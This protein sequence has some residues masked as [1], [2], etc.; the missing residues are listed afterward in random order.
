MWF[1]CTQTH[2]HIQTNFINILIDLQNTTKLA[3]V[4]QMVDARE[5]EK[6]MEKL[7]VFENKLFIAEQ[8][9]EKEIQK[10]LENIRRHVRFLHFVF[11][12]YTVSVFRFDSSR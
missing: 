10:K 4:K 1:A 2:T 9:R 5:N 6:A 11:I 3:E 7:H 8:N 12:F